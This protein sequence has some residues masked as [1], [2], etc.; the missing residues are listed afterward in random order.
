LHAA[1]VWHNAPRGRAIEGRMHEPP[2]ERLPS[3]V[4]ANFVLGVQLLSARNAAISA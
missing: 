3:R 1:R 2:A 4:Y